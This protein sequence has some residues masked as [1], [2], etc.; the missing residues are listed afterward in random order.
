L[1]SEPRFLGDLPQ[2]LGSCDITQCRRDERGIAVLQHRLEV[3][4]DIPRSLQVIGSVP[5]L[6][7]YLGHVQPSFSACAIRRAVWMSRSWLRL[8]PPASSM[9]TLLPPLV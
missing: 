2:A 9:T 7:S 6:G 4:R 1:P 3:S 8:S 5:G